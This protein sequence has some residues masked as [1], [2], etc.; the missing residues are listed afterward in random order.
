MTARSG[1]L[2]GMLG[3]G[4]GAPA[5]AQNLVVDGDFDTVTS[6]ASWPPGFFTSLEWTPQDWQ[7]DPG[8]GS[9]RLTNQA[10]C[11]G[12]FALQCVDLPEPHAALYEFGVAMY[13]DGPPQLVSAHVTVQAWD[14]A[15]CQG[16]PVLSF[17]SATANQQRTWS[18]FFQSG[19]EVPASTRSVG[20]R[21]VVSKLP[22]M[23]NCLPPLGPVSARFDDVRFGPAGTTPVT[24]QS[25]SVE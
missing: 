7:G 8:S 14:G 12:T 19:F 17:N 9:M 4:L 23:P 21:L 18:W 16:V 22:F 5:E 20:I 24:L 13:L 1:L 2:L 10:P 25:F 3:L 11:G 6:L 15:A